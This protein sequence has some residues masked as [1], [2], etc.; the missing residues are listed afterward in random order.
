MGWSIV[1]HEDARVVMISNRGKLSGVDFESLREQLR[2]SNID[3]N[4][5]VLIDL[6]GATEGTLPARAI[7]TLAAG[8][9]VFAASS[10]RAVIVRTLLGVGLANMYSMWRGRRGAAFR[11]FRDEAEARAYVGLPPGPAASTSHSRV[12]GP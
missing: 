8:A 11:V 7:S 9:P 6:R 3:R 10:K 4:F 1:V 2:A 5:S 12:D